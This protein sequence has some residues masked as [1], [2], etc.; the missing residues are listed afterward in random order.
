MC[1]TEYHDQISVL[2]EPTEDEHVATKG[3]VDDQ[4][5][6]ATG[7]VTGG[8]GETGPTGP[9]GPTG[10]PG[11]GGT[12]GTGGGGGGA[13][14]LV[15]DLETTGEMPPGTHADGTLAVDWG[16]RLHCYIAAYGGWIEMHA[17]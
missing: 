17:N 5:D 2:V 6:Q 1:P 11:T 4:I 3:Y 8:I 12:G 16:M 9:T 14:I 13:H 7:G 10:D 15:G